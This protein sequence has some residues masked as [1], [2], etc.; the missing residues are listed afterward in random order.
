MHTEDGASSSKPPP[1]RNPKAEACRSENQD[2]A[3]I[4]DLL[5]EAEEVELVQ[6]EIVS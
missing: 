2:K 6:W 1:T 3:D 5:A 4:C